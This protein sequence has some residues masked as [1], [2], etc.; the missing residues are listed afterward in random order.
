MSMADVASNSVT[1]GPSKLIRMLYRRAMLSEHLRRILSRSISENNLST[2]AFEIGKQ[3]KS[4]TRRSIFVHCEERGEL[5]N[6][7]QTRL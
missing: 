4:S 3:N 6:L 5:N 1:D 7:Y 2:A